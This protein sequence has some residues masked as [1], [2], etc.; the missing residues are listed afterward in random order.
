MI[1]EGDVSV[2]FCDI[3]TRCG[4]VWRQ[5]CKRIKYMLDSH[6]LKDVS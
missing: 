5:A 1:V 4:S 2:V 3:I 6:R